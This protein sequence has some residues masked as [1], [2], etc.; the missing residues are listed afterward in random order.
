MIFPKCTIGEKTIYFFTVQ[1]QSG[2]LFVYLKR[3]KLTQLEYIYF[4]YAL[5]II[6]AMR[7]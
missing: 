5:E 3:P 7:N 6:T 1:V 4:R 2:I